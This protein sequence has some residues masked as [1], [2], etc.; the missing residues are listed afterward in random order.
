MKI[1]KRDQKQ[2]IRRQLK[3]YFD[4][5]NFVF[6]D[7]TADQ[8]T[9]TLMTKWG[10][11]GIS[12]DY[13]TSGRHYFS[14]VYISH[15]NVEQ[16]IVELGLPNHDFSSRLKSK[17]YSLTTVF[18]SQTDLGYSSERYPVQTINQVEDYS[19]SIIKYM[20]Q[21]GWAFTKS[22]SYL[23][24]V[25][26][27]MNRLEVQGKYWNGVRGEGGLLDG[28][29]SSFFRGLI[30]SKLCNDSDYG[31]KVEMVDKIFDDNADEW[32]LYYNQLK[33]QLGYV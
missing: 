23:P 2:I 24:N 21:Q 30:V 10:M 14:K 31:R 1:S 28:G 32:F 20:E 18:D 22:Y 19:Q 16:I 26:T 8:D 13:K 9:F 17:D 15:F 25:L 7:G 12:L 33:H 6:E 3:S 27:E 5:F 4:D 29:S 11:I